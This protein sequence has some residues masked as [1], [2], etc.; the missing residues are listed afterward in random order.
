MAKRGTSQFLCFCAFC[1]FLEVQLELSI[2]L[3]E[4]WQFLW[5][6]NL[7]V[8]FCL[9]SSFS[10]EHQLFI[11]GRG[12]LHLLE[13]QLLTQPINLHAMPIKRRGRHRFKHSK[14]HC[15]SKWQLCILEYW[16]NN[17][18]LYK[19]GW[20]PIIIIIIIKTKIKIWTN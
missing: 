18:H 13:G 10:V 3:G 11:G 7:W 15:P 1:I 4:Q 14:K 20:N 5:E 16:N 19:Y 12:W 9:A 6:S 17:Y 2:K 8:D